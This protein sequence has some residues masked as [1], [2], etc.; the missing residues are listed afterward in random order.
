MLKNQVMN[1]LKAYLRAKLHTIFD[2]DFSGRMY[3]IYLASLKV[4][5]EIS[6]RKNKDSVQ[7]ELTNGTFSI[8]IDQISLARFERITGIRSGIRSHKSKGKDF[9]EMLQNRFGKKERVKSSSSI[10]R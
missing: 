9:N 5:K 3:D 1:V 4:N 2:N 8:P 10:K 7:F 6:I